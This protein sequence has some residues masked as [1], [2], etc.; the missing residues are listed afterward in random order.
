MHDRPPANFRRTEPIEA[1]ELFHRLLSTFEPPLPS[2]FLP[3]DSAAHTPLTR[4]ERNGLPKLS[5]DRPAVVVSST[6]WTADEDF[7]LLL[8]AL[9]VYQKAKSANPSLPRLLVLI[10]GRGA[11]RPAFER[12]VAMREADGKQKRWTDIVCRCLFLPARDYPLL[13]GCADLGV[14][15]HTSSSGRDLPMKV[16]D[17]FGCGLPVCAKNFACLGELVVDGKNGRVFETGDELG[18]QMIVRPSSFSPPPPR[19]HPRLG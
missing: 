18:A 6:S 2:S 4:M 3:S 15:L 17:M 8:R 12:A 9:D 16:V 14:S 1:H 19:V 11:Y 7:S 13:L 10:T 5:D